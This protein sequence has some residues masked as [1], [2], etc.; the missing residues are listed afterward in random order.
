M[1]QLSIVSAIFTQAEVDADPKVLDP[2]AIAYVIDYQGNVFEHK[3]L[4]S[5]G[6]ATLKLKEAPER[7]KKL[8]PTFSEQI[9]HLPGGKIPLH[10]FSQICSF[11]KKVMREKGHGQTTTTTATWRG[12]NEAMAHILWN[13]VSKQYEVG[14]PTQKVASASVD[15]AYDD[16]TDNHV[17]IIDVHSHNN[18][19]AFWSTRDDKEDAKGVWYSGVVGTIDKGPSTNWRFSSNGEFRKVE[20]TDI[21]DGEFK[22]VNFDVEVP[23][24]W[25]DKVSEYV[26][27]AP[28]YQQGSYLGNGYSYPNTGAYPGSPRRNA[29]DSWVHR[30]YDSLEEFYTEVWGKGNAPLAN[31]GNP[32]IRSQGRGY[33]PD[34]SFSDMRTELT[35]IISELATLGTAAETSGIWR[36]RITLANQVMGQALYTILE[37]FGDSE[38]ELLFTVLAKSVTNQRRSNFARRKVREQLR[39]LDEKMAKLP[40]TVGNY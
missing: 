27:T 10:L 15:F 8:E 31:R 9:S 37:S 4:A 1:K 28:T 24:A 36:P 34:I 18:M 33:R 13:K 14:I 17:I 12:S 30:D 40:S 7:L 6:F 5:G 35:D 23:Q 19:G 16:V 21:Y 2:W 22:D 11:F 20:F 3:K 32:G 25:M 39:V 29:E 26:Y 38:M